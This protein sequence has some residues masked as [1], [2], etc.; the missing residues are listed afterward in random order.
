M[1]IDN[2]KQTNHVFEVTFQL[3]LHGENYVIY[4]TDTLN[5]SVL[6]GVYCAC[7]APTSN[8]FPRCEQKKKEASFFVPREPRCRG[9]PVSVKSVLFP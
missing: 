7:I 8:F 5:G 2:N 6:R 9:R 3:R 1:K 4:R